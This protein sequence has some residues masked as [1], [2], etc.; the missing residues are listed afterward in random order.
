MSDPRRYTV[1]WICAVQSELVAAL[2]F[3]DG[4]QHE[5]LEST[6]PNDDNNYV[7][8]TM[9]NHNVVIATLPMQE[10]GI[11][12]A[13]A[14]AS[15]LQRTFTNI[16]VGLMVGIGGGAPS[17]N[18]DVRLGDIVVNTGGVHQYDFGKTMQDRKLVTTGDLNRPPRL[19]RARVN[20][21]AAQHANGN[22]IHT[23]ITALLKDK[24]RLNSYRRPPLSSDVLYRA[25]YIH[26]AENQ[27][28]QQVCG[29]RSGDIV[30]R[31]KRGRYDHNPAVHHGKIASANQV[32]KDAM[33]RDALV[34]EHKVLCF[35]MEAAGL[36]NNFP[37]LVIRGICDYADSHKNKQWQGYAAMA[38]A[39]YAKQLLA[40]IPPHEVELE[41][42]AV[43]ILEAS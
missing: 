2:Q 9:G 27:A 11:A 15:H 29:S 8:G 6:P 20:T 7:L 30:S 42:R 39:A 34:A 13:A 12:S 21:L 36:A 26:Q 37:C 41:Q 19:L 14:V 35:E 10:Y 32:M 3:L 31:P 17:S 33:V 22:D 40:G 23:T 5:Q 43:E 24:Q 38:A 1:G 28:C 16:R 18:Q 25:D 4:P